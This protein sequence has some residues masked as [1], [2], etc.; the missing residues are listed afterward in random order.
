MSV[1]HLSQV[2]LA[3]HSIPRNTLD[4]NAAID[5]IHAQFMRGEIEGARAAFL[6]RRLEKIAEKRKK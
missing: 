5:K 3:H 1:P 2:A 6:V 4:V